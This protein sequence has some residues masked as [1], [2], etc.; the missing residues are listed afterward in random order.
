MPSEQRFPDSF[1]PLFADGPAR[2]CAACLTP[3]T[4]DRMNLLQ[5]LPAIDAHGPRYLP[6]CRRTLP[7]THVPEPFGVWPELLP[8]VDTIQNYALTF[9]RY[10]SMR[11]FVSLKVQVNVTV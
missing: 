5:L 11:I 9:T 2:P 6:R 1:S 7:T 10:L 3:V 8:A 4:P